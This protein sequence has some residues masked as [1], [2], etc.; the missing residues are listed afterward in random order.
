MNRIEIR[1]WSGSVLLHAVLIAALLWMQSGLRKPLRKPAVIEWEVS[2]FEPAPPVAA[3]PSPLPPVHEK[4]IVPLPRPVPRTVARVES[5]EVQQPQ[6]E[7]PAPQEVPAARSEAPVPVVTPPPRPPQPAPQLPFADGGWIGQALSGLMN[8]RKRYPLQARR[9]GVE[10]KVVIEAVIDE[11]GR[12]VE[13]GIKSSSGSP[14]LDQ[15]A[16]VLLRSVP[17]LKPEKMKLAARTVVEI[18]V[19]YV[20]EQ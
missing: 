3:P 8:A 4:P 17:P 18:P 12:V 13:A 1:H 19:S 11:G 6:P 16:L 14:I 9:M 5:P 10:G 20:L 2:F 7:K 15:D